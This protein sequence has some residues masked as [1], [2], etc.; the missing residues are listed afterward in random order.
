MKDTLLSSK[1][2]FLIFSSIILQY[3]LHSQQ[4]SI[5]IEKRIM[6]GPESEQLIIMRTRSFIFNNLKIG[7]ITEAFEA[8]NYALNKFESEKVKPFKMM[9]K[10]LLCF[11]FGEYDLIYEADVKGTIIEPGFRDFY[12]ENFLNYYLLN[13]LSSLYDIMSVELRLLSNRNRTDIIKRIDSLVF[14]DEK[15]DYLILF[16]DRFT[17]D[18]T[19]SVMAYKQMKDYLENELTPR[20]EKFLAKYK[21]SQFENFVRQNFRF[22][23]ALNDWGYGFQLGLGAL[24]PRGTI[25]EYFN[26]EAT[27]DL[28]FNLSWK[29]L[30]FDVGFGIGIP[31]RA[32]KPFIYDGENWVT[33][34]KYN[35]YN[36]NLNTGFVAIENELFKISPH[37]GIGVINISV[38]EAD[39]K[40]IEDD[41]SMSQ[42]IIQIGITGDVKWNKFRFQFEDD[43]TSYTG[44]SI[45][46][47][48]SQFLG[49][50]PIM[51]DGMFRIRLSWVGFSRTIIRVI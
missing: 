4:D 26:T 28:G 38:S 16:F 34:I 50:N 27:F 8:Y 7:N 11:W 45:T 30:L 19:D 24:I 14:D 25:K 22:V 23:Y 6:E 5:S 12:F 33:G 18:A 10:Y 41:L 40:K 46:F 20:A 37:L 1:F 21:D 9:E 49:N 3:N 44:I 39:K 29:K 15:H 2:I 35:Y 17:F 43:I 51:S 36:F 31:V 32:K 48:Y 42:G 13:Q 47:D